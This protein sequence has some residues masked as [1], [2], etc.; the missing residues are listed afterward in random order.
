MV[1]LA[2]VMKTYCRTGMAG[3]KISGRPSSSAQ[4]RSWAMVYE[5]LMPCE[6]VS[7][8][9]TRMGMFSAEA[10]LLVRRR[11]I[12]SVICA[13]TGAEEVCYGALPRG[14]RKPLP[15]AR[16]QWFCLRPADWRWAGRRRQRAGQTAVDGRRTRA[17]EEYSDQPNGHSWS[18]CHKRIRHPPTKPGQSGSVLHSR[19]APAVSPRRRMRT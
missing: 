5:T 16:S 3:A 6:T 15:S 18:L 1:A 8:G 9:S 14:L 17:R 2:W 11:V 10:A 7:Q 19:V 13:L 12:A 4:L